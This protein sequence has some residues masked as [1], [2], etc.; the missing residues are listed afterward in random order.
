[1]PGAGLPSGLTSIGRTWCPRG[2]IAHA[3]RLLFVG[4]V[5]AQ[6]VRVHRLRAPRVNAA[7][8]R[9]GH[10]RVPVAGAALG[11]RL[12]AGGEVDARLLLPDDARAS[13][14]RT[15]G[16]ASAP[17]IFSFVTLTCLGCNDIVPVSRVARM[18][19]M[20][21]ATTGVLYLAV[22]IARLV[23]LYSRP[24]LRETA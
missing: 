19:M 16:P 17:F 9:R 21:E 12:S 18:L 4:F 6:L 5:V 7:V 2:I 13:G 23:A 20:V 15:D 3:L 22:M 8:L 24:N 1:M 10:L 11:G 14:D